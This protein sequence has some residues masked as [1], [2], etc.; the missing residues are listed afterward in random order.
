MTVAPTPATCA[1]LTACTRPGIR[2]LDLGTGTGASAR[3]LVAAGAEVTTVENDAAWFRPDAA[4]GARHVLGDWRD[5]HDERF[6]LVF[7]DHFPLEDRREAALTWWLAGAEVIVDEANL[8]SLP[9]T[10]G[11]EHPHDRHLGLRHLT[12]KE[13]LL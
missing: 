9:R 13:C 1:L 12:V 5:L 10:L 4:P 6:D 8:T 3:A 11:H 7:V 2:A